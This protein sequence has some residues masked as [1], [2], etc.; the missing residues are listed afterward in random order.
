MITSNFVE[1]LNAYNSPKLLFKK[2][3]NRQC[4]YEELVACVKYK[5][6]NKERTD[7]L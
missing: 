7:S 1:L 4:I 3:P 2:H 6:E 5:K